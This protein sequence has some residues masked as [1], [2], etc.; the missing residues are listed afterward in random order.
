MIENWNFD[1]GHDQD[2]DDDQEICVNYTLK[3]K[4]DNTPQSLNVTTSNTSTS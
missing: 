4:T 3:R 1:D 2:E